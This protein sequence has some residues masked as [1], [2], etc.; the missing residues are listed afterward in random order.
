VADA[1]SQLAREAFVVGATYRVTGIA[2]QR[3]TK[4]DAPDGYRLCPRDAADVIAVAAAAILPGAGSSGTPGA[5]TSRPAGVAD[6]AT[7]AT[8][9]IKTALGRLDD[10]VAIEGTVTAPAALL[11]TTGRR[12]VV[13]DGSAA[14]E[15][16]LPGGTAA[17]AVGTRIRASGLVGVAYGAPRLRADEITVIGTAQPPSPLVLRAS[18][19]L[20]HEWRLVSIT[21]R[22]DDVRKLGDRWR[23][24]ILV[25]GA[26]VVVV[27]QP[28]AGI[29]ATALVEGRM[30]S[31][32]GIVRRPYPTATDQRY[33]ITP[34]SRADVRVHGAAATAG[35]GNAT[36]GPKPGS[37]GSTAPEARPAA[38]AGAVDADLVDL[39][40]FSGRRVR[41]GGLVV[42][43]RS[44]GLLVD[45]GTTIGLVVVRGEALELLPLLEPDDAINA[46]GVV[47][48]VPDGFAVAVDEPG[49]IIQ[50]GDPVAPRGEAIPSERTGA[51]ATTHGTP[52]GGSEATIRDAGIFDGSSGFGTG[53]VGLAGLGALMGLSLASLV[54][55]LARRALARRR[56]MARVATRVAAFEA[57]AGPP[58]GAPPG[59]PYGPRSAERDDS[60]IHAA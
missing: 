46:V 47:E 48:R 59:P 27:G 54:V 40:A 14:I 5:P 55:T 56:L 31:I 41:V 50:A 53:L 39:A 43:L 44:D 25:S 42:D 13:Q 12:I 17:P 26:K 28:G 57:S 22:I 36:G 21:G 3:A 29:V 1:S 8:V 19:G 7:G 6:S 4:K 2:G 33:A 58:H 32:T 9:P 24:E 15:L 49:G 18:P 34:R 20:A 23:A 35:S 45:D 60:T 30:A 16:L 51:D 37:T 11:D 52:A 38:A 10:P